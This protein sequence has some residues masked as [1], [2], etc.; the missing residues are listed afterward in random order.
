MTTKA[1]DASLIPETNSP[2]NHNHN[3]LSKTSILHHVFMGAWNFLYAKEWNNNI[4]T[5]L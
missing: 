3:K 4:S 5:L 2:K 1:G